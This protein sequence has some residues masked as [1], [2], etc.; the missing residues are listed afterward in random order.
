MEAAV[1]SDVVDAAGV[2]VGYKTE[3]K[4]LTQ[5]FIHVLPH[6]DD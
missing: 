2:V 1:I 5:S 6:C 3:K 4:N